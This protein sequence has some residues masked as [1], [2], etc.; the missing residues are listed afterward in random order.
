MSSARAVHVCAMA[1]AASVLCFFAG[2][3]PH[4]FDTGELV[5]AAFVLGGSHPPGQPLHAIL[6]FA[7][8]LLPFGPATFRVTLVSV[9]G[10][11]AAA[12]IGGAL[13]LRLA[14]GIRGAALP[15]SVVM[16]LPLVVGF[17]LLVSPPVL[18]QATRPEV[19]TVALALFALSMWSL[20]PWA[21]KGPRA[22]QSLHV[23]ALAAGLAAGLHPPHGLSALG[24]GLA[25]LL[26]CRR[27]LLRRPRTLGEAALFFVVGLGPL[28]LLPIRGEAGAPMWGDPTTFD[29][30]YAYVSATA[31]RQNLGA[32]GG[33]FSDQVLTVVRYL[34]YAAGIV[35][36]FGLFALARSARGATESSR[37][38]IIGALA[39]TAAALAGALVT[40]IDESIP[41]MVAYAG[42]PVFVLVAFGAAGMALLARPRFAMLGLVGVALSVFAIRDAPSAVNAD[43]PV[44]DALGLSLTSTPPPRS[45]VIVTEDFTGSTWMMERAVS[46]ARP[47]VALFVSGLASSSWHWRSLS[48]H[49]VFDGTPV[50]GPGHDPHQR[51]TRGAMELAAGAVPIAVE[52]DEWSGGQGV[53]AGAY[54]IGDPRLEM[55]VLELSAGERLAEAVGALAREGSAGDH[56]VVLAIYRAY[57]TRRAHRLASRGRTESAMSSLALAFVDPTDAERAALA[58]G[59]GPMDSTRL[60][61]VVREPATPGVT[62]GATTRHAAVLL[63]AVGAD[64]AA[65]DLLE[66]QRASD[67]RAIL[68]VGWIALASGRPEVARQALNE[69]DAAAPHLS[70][71]GE[72]L[73]RRL[74]P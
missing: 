64:D 68:Q 20:V 36:L 67:P 46:G 62:R 10:A 52:Q 23:A 43:A 55:S 41:D 74:S 59:T 47:D 11:V 50:A 31:Y 48:P 72:S 58:A 28:A 29:G 33:S 14:R 26:S 35:P 27:D 54:L 25:L 60:S 15:P 34:P 70:T 22:T 21:Q 51:Y 7:A 69:F 42:P 12:A 17:A 61:Y 71:E 9:A 38:L 2:S 45:L 13:S 66:R 56:D 4:A 24:V 37:A 44:L 3:G 1:V 49:P 8:T 16:V 57:E 39:A 73:S 32:A 30:F 18:R 53:L 5:A 6:G 40:P 65:L 19:Y 63:A